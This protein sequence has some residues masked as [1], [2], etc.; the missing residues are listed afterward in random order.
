MAGR[1]HGRPPAQ[2]A[3]VRHRHGQRLVRHLS[4]GPARRGP[5]AET[6]F[7]RRAGGARL[8]PHAGRRSPAAAAGHGGH[9]AAPARNLGGAGHHGLAGAR[10]LRHGPHAGSPFPGRHHPGGGGGR[11]L[12]DA[13]LDRR[14]AG[15][16]GRGAGVLP[17]QPAVAAGTLA[18]V[19]GLD[20]RRADAGLVAARH[21]G[22]G[23]RLLDTQL[24]NLDPGLV[25][26][27][28]PAHHR[29]HAARPAL[30]PVADLAAGPAGD[31]AL[32]RLAVCAPYLGAA[33]AGRHRGA[34]AAVPGRAQ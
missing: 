20:R 22:R 25:R 13:R 15:D 1:Y 10:V 30:V 23:Q 12:P 18:A 16:G 34:D 31:L 26:L 27:A 33:G 11:R 9:P 32:A 5:A 4:A 2:P 28:G 7:R 21:P 3:V 24:E 19:G 14:R 6:A 17:A 29:P 8:R